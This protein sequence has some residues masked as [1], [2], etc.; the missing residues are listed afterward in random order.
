[1][2]WLLACSDASEGLAP[3]APATVPVRPELAPLAGR[4]APVEAG[5]DGA[6]ALACPTDSAP[7]VEIRGDA[8]DG[9]QLMTGNAD[10]LE[11]LPIT[12]VEGS[13][14]RLSIGVDGG[15]PV[16][17]AWVEPNRIAKF[18]TLYYDQAFVIPSAK[19]AIPSAP[20][21]CP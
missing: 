11:V 19:A 14:D 6:W 12:T 7:F 9:W 16:Q 13:A 17:L 3:T 5:A 2:W 10:Q 1:M 4:W 20:G 18:P 8:V 15:S 21:G